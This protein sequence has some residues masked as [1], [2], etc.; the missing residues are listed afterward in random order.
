MEAMNDTVESDP[1]VYPFWTP[2]GNCFANS[3]VSIGHHI[4]ASLLLGKVIDPMD[5][6][7]PLV[8]CVV[9][10]RLDVA[11]IYILAVLHLKLQ[12]PLV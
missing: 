2:M 6:Y 10:C 3:A 4:V 8:P 7:A 11:N 12:H 9:A 1:L 5:A